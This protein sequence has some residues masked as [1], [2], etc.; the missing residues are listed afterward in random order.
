MVF[1]IFRR[2]DKAVRRQG[3]WRRK[4]KLVQNC[5]CPLYKAFAF[6]RQCAATSNRQRFSLSRWRGIKNIFRRPPR[7]CVAP[8]DESLQFYG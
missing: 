1:S 5:V 2:P 6:H 8:P 7:L 3:R 4:R